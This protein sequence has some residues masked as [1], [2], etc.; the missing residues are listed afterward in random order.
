MADITEI[1]PGILARLDAQIQ[2]GTAARLAN[3]DNDYGVP[4]RPFFLTCE[5]WQQGLSTQED[6]EAEP[7]PQLIRLPVNPSKVNFK[8]GLRQA[9]ARTRAGRI[10]F[11]WKNRDRKTFLDEPVLTF[12][13]QAGNIL[14]VKNSGG[15]LRIARGLRAFWNFMR[16][17][18]EE[19]II[20]PKIGG[21][22]PKNVGEPNYVIIEYSSRK[23]PLLRL[24]G[25]F[26][27]EGVDFDDEAND[28]L[29]LDWTAS[30]TVYDSQ[31]RFSNAA[32]LELAFSGEGDSF[33]LG[34]PLG[35]PSGAPGA[36]PPP[37][38]APAG[39][40]GSANTGPNPLGASAGPNVGPTGPSG[41]AASAGSPPPSAAPPGSPVGSSFTGAGTSRNPGA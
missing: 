26:T 28:P 39:P 18:D 3:P 2:A 5:L 25:F 40:V 23:F 8:I 19:K 15:Q 38:P 10:L 35:L 22:T 31:P 30:F 7:G 32:D 9:E 41:S 36:P 16:L 17:L 33:Q 1:D 11:V 27:P 14:S 6:P 20:P 4:R 24:K 13:F 12:T 37:A 34:S 21:Q 29:R